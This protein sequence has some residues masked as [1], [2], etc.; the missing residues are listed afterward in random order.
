MHSSSDGSGAVNDVV[1][2][3]YVHITL[4]FCPVYSEFVP[5]SPDEGDEVL[6]SRLG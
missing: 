3:P 2:P 4:H 6:Y 5:I 1:F